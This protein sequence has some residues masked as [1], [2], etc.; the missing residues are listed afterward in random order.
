MQVYVHQFNGVATIHALPLAAGVLV[1]TARSSVRLG[2]SCRFTIVVERLAPDAVV[3]GYDAPDV[4][5][6][7]MYTWNERYTLE[8]V[9]RARLRHPAALTVCG[10]PSVPR[11]AEGLARLAAAHPW[12]D[13]WVV[14]EGEATFCELLEARLEGRGLEG[15]AGVGFWRE[16]AWV[17]SAARPRLADLGW[18]RSPYLDGTYDGLLAGGRHRFNAMVLETN[19]GCPFA[20]TF[21][22]WGGATQSRVTELPMERVLAELEWM[23]AQGLP[24]LYIIDANFGIR[25]RDQSITDAVAALKVRSGMPQSCHFH[26]TKNA[27]RRN[28]RTVEV[29]R[30]AGVACRMALSMQDFDADVLEAIK[31]ANIKLERS[32]ALRRACNARG[33]PTFNELLLGLPAQTYG[34]FCRSVVTAMTPFP[35]DTFNL[36]L[37]RLLENAEMASPAD[38]ARFGLQTVRCPATSQDASY[39]A[40]V[41]EFEEL[42]VGSAVMSTSDWARAFRFGHLLGVL[43]N[44]RVLR[45]LLHDLQWLEGVDVGAWLEVLVAT[46]IE[47]PPTT[48]LGRLEAVFA[49]TTD[50]ILGGGPAMLELD[51]VPGMRWD[52]PEALLNTL[53]EVADAFFAEVEAVT[54]SWLGWSGE[55]EARLVELLAFSR[56]TLPGTPPSEGR[57]EGFAWDWQGHLAAIAEGRSEPVRRVGAQAVRT[58]SG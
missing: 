49:R 55:R 27:H 45:L 40:H 38:R 56:A 3:A 5:A 15:V 53:I 50:S 14:G 31:R 58:G 1:A 54:R 46:M 35:Q 57:L 37:A 22:D 26:L 21:C 7:S 47:A 8:V 10:G 33:I 52:I 13:V 32:V 23:A 48:A 34:S 25:P 28:L 42:V 41:E 6:F 24:T 17:R 2:A 44:L 9:R 39:E 20:C 51:G 11:S 18:T 29:L 16:G 43:Y 4:L 30:E 19:R 36:Y 12:V